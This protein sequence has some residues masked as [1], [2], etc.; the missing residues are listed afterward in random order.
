MKCMSVKWSPSPLKTG[1]KAHLNFDA[2][3]RPKDSGRPSCFHALRLFT[4]WAGVSPKRFLSYVT[5]GHAVQRL[6]ES[7]SVLDA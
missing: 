1:S 6:E 3:G 2:E 7:A 4:R 5:V